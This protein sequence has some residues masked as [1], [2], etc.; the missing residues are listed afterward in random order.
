MLPIVHTLA[1]DADILT[2]RNAWAAQQT[3][4]DLYFKGKSLEKT[5]RYADDYKKFLDEQPSHLQK[6]YEKRPR[7]VGLDLKIATDSID[8]CIYSMIKK[9]NVGNVVCYLTDE[10]KSNFRYKIATLLPYKADRGEKPKFYR[11]CREHLM[12][13]WNAQVIVG[14]EADDAMAQLQFPHY[15][16]LIYGEDR[17]DSDITMIASLDKD[18]K[19]VPGYHYD[20]SD[21]AELR[22]IDELQGL[23]N[24]YTQLLTGDKSVDNIPGLFQICK[25]KVMP[26][27]KAPLQD[28]TT[29]VEM[30]KY[31][32]SIWEKNLPKE[33]SVTRGEGD[34]IE[35]ET[36]KLNLDEVLLEIG[37]LLWMR[38]FKGKWWTFPA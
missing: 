12:D 9:F 30:Y 19:M 17:S 26:K 14:E 28:C 2:Y 7:E 20:F 5:F 6:H 8:K 37:N 33:Y 23:R 25:K 31:V 27:M 13:R 24:F 34:D 29:E 22:W 4:Y 21:K 35:V 32:R 16:R 3:H 36:I 18:L 1:V 10:E 11:Q 38:R 15:Q